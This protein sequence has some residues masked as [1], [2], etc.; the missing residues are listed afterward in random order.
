MSPKKIRNPI[1][2]AV[3]AVLILTGCRLFSSIGSPTPAATLSSE[4]PTA[5]ARPADQT[6]GIISSPAEDMTRATNQAVLEACD[7]DL[8]TK[9]M[10]AGNVP[11][12]D[13][14]PIS[15]CYDLELDLSSGGPNYTGVSKV[16]YTNNTSDPL[17]YLV[18]RLYPNA[19]IIYGGSLEITS[20]RMGEAELN[21]DIFLEDETAARLMLPEP[22]G[23]GNTTVL[24]FT[25]EGSLPV[26]FQNAGTYGIYNFSSAGPV[27]AMANAYPILAVR[28]GN[29]WRADSV[30]GLGD[31]VLSDTALYKAAI[32]LPEGWQAVA[33][34][35][36]VSTSPQADRQVVQIAS[37]P[38]REFFLAA[39]PVFQTEERDLGDVK[40]RFWATADTMTGAAETLDTASA[41][42]TL[43]DE[44]FGQY[45]YS[46]FDL[47]TVPLNYASGVEYPGLT[48]LLSEMYTG[49]QDLTWLTTVITHETAHQWWYSVVGSDVIRHPW[50]DEALATYSAQLYEQAY[51]YP[52]YAGTNREYQRRV[53][54]IEAD[55]GEQDID[56]SL[57]AFRDMPQA[58]SAIVYL[59]GSLFFEAVQD[60]IGED[61]TRPALETYYR[62]NQYRTV[63][64]SSLLDSFENACNC[65]LDS[66]YEEWGV[67]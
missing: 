5:T 7:I 8:Q 32:I 63:Q 53:D 36:V 65:S 26:D 6:P 16:T 21:P 20:A 10:R 27:L 44:L 67:Q 49:D 29:A 30:N 18:F 28:E 42:M 3:A 2:A 12:W 52:V 15:A 23:V 14:I 47:V 51:D 19:A 33:S 39:S 64:P 48:L 60:K 34:G 45:P 11:A 58:Y 22:L 56:Q 61:A 40:L 9:A 41:A 66:L 55:L 24:N 62:D 17:E 54:Q 35:S 31:A 38:I 1:T 50:Q 59:K 37:G 46:E 25:F 43:F 13:S 4:H 57:E